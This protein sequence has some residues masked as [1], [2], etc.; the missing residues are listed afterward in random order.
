MSSVKQEN[1]FDKISL[2]VQDK[3]FENE[4]EAR[5]LEC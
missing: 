4:Q 3:T 5:L 2:N 1:A